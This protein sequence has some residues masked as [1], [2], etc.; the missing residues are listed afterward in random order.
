M[1]LMDMRLGA[2]D[3]AQRPG[4]GP[5]RS[6]PLPVPRSSQFLRSDPAWERHSSLHTRLRAPSPPHPLLER[7]EDSG[8]GMADANATFDR[9]KGSLER[10]REDLS[11]LERAASM[12]GSEQPLPPTRAPSMSRIPSADDK[13]RPEG[14]ARMSCGE[15]SPVKR[16]LQD[17]ENTDSEIDIRIEL[18]LELLQLQMLR[19]SVTSKSRM[20]E[21]P[22]GKERG[23]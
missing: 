14:S 2:T 8:P 13:P 1:L 3:R 12:D 19:N 16:F 5:P 20:L 9:L 21:A 17:L 11:M 23:I 4:Q 7:S 22:C 18:E 10:H 15:D 6:Q